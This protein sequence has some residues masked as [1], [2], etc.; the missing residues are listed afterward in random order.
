MAYNKRLLYTISVPSWDTPEG[1]LGSFTQ[2]GNL[3]N[4]I[5]LS[6]TN[7]PFSGVVYSISPGSSLPNGL[8]ISSSGE[9]SG[10]LTG[11]TI[12]EIVNFSIRATDSEGE[13]LDRSFSLT[14]LGKYYADFLSVAGGGGGGWDV[15]GGGGA[16]GLRTSY[17]SISGRNSSPESKLLLTPGSL[18]TITVGS[19]GSGAT[20]SVGTSGQ[21]QPGENTSISGTGVNIT[22][23]GGGLGGNY[24]GGGGGS[25]GSGGG[26]S[27]YGIIIGGKG[28]GTINQGFDGGRAG[29][30]GGSAETGAGGGGAGGAGQNTVNGG[31][32]YG[33]S[34]LSI[35]IT[36]SSVTYSKGGNGRQDSASGH[37]AGPANTGNGGDGAGSPN[38]GKN[39]GS[40]ILILRFPTVSYTGITTGSPI[41]TTVGSDTILTYTGSGTYTS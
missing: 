25:G 8:T 3:I 9:I 13:F 34:G 16:G 23:I 7:D 17:G 29:S 22:S 38:N 31:I 32:S 2:N 30:G 28:G 12:S 39:G 35:S 27:G 41:V 18:Y 33:G 36:G 26:A 5:Q 14:V 24:A 21:S 6:A 20:G 11:Y 15:G 4:P 10:T 40:G 37:V 1:N 19:G